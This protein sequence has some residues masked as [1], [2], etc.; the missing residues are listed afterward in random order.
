MSNPEPT[1]AKRVE[2]FDPNEVYN[3]IMA[4]K[5]VEEQWWVPSPDIYLLLWQVCGAWETVVEHVR[6]LK[7]ALKETP[8]TEAPFVWPD[9]KKVASDMRRLA[10]DVNLRL[11]SNTFWNEECDRARTMRDN[12]GHMLHFRSVEGQPPNQVVTV[13]RVPYFEPDEMSVRGN[14]PIELKPGEKDNRMKVA[15]HNRVTVTIT[16]QDAREVLAGL[17]YVHS[18]IFA[19]RKFGIEFAT[20]PDGRSTESVLELM[21]WWL[22][23]WGPKPGEDGWA[24]PTMGQLRIR[25]KAEFDA[26]LPEGNRPEF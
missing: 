7:Y 12:L 13:L 24:A 22:D 9:S 23:D 6:G 17:E 4:N 18:C 19:I 21:R 10:K 3:R 5:K 2:T 26:S 11:P 8:P 15:V 14:E 20:W 16:A 1:S 25:P